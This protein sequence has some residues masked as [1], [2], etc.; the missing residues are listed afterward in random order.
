MKK[1]ICFLL[2]NDSKRIELAHN[3]NEFVQDDKLSNSC[4]KF[5]ITLKNILLNNEKEK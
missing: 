5:E 1:N 4:E 2:D 3:G